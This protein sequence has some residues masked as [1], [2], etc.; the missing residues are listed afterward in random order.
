[1]RKFFLT[2]EH[3]FETVCLKQSAIDFTSSFKPFAQNTRSKATSEP[4][5]LVSSSEPSVLVSSS[6]SLS[7]LS[8]RVRAYLC[9]CVCACVRACV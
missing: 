2:L 5:V 6:L 3:L 7:L 9:V 4:S 8:A 1:M